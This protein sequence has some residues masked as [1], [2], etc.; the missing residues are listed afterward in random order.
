MTTVQAL[1]AELPETA[2]V[3]PLPLLR[4]IINDHLGPW[5]ADQQS[6]AVKS[7]AIRPVPK[8][9][10][11]VAGRNPRKYAGGRGLA[12]DRGQAVLILVA[13]TLAFAAGIAVVAMIRAIRVS[14]VDPAVF[15]QAP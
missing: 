11:K 14:G 6:Y 1:I 4:S 7:G 9:P 12:V 8:T 15:V 5:D 13:A 3:I 2:E 10:G